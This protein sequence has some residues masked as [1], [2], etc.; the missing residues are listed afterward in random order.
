[1]GIVFCCCN[2]N[3]GFPKI[4]EKLCTIWVVCRMVFIAIYGD[5]LDFGI[6]V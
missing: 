5:T 1:M 4:R 6:K 3:Q 2:C